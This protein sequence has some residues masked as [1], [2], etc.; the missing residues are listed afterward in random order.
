MDDNYVK[1]PYCNQKL[2]FINPSHL[3]LH[4]KTTDIMK[5]EFP[6]QP[7]MCK[8][9]TKKIFKNSNIGIKKKKSIKYIKKYLSNNSIP[10]IILSEYY[11][12]SRL[13]L[14]WKCDK[15][16]IFSMS[17]TEFQQGNR[18]PVCFGTF[19][20]SKKEIEK[21]LESI[22]YK[23]LGKVYHNGYSKL[24]LLCPNNH[25]IIMRFD[26]LIDG[27]RCQ[28]CN[29]ET[30]KKLFSG[31]GNP[32][33]KGGY[34]LNNIPSYKVYTPRLIP[35]E[36]TRRNK[37]DRN[38]LEVNCTYCGKWFIPKLTSVMERIRSLDGRQAGENR[39]YCSNECKQ[40][41]PIYWQ[42]KYPRG[43]KSSTI[44]REV[45]PELRQ[46]RFKVDNYTCQKCK[47][48]Q[49]ELDVPLHCHHLEGI[50]WEP[51]ESADLDKVITVCADCHEK[52]HK[53]EGCG[54]HDM[55]CPDKYKT[56]KR[57]IE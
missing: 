4:G 56:T 16:H 15:G 11:K 23:W 7:L 17:W 33:W 34:S 3:K 13:K 19:K 44:T 55:K 42:Q 26:S 51:L 24:K 40:A 54:Y 46:M 12:N 36:T 5:K 31:K 57:K 39:F 25:I 21:F 49:D 1:C 14:K 8:N 48:H 41:C 53:I 9:T 2:K 47:K 28:K 6:N 29:N 27:H 18:C 45:Q 50:R 37:N 32:N 38:I 35:V 52:I 22:N 43:Y 30:K 10:Y 20:R